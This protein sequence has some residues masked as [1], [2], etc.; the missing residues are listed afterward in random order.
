M[1]NMD[2]VKSLIIGLKTE[3]ALTK[4]E[5][6]AINFA[7]MVLGLY[8]DMEASVEAEAK[9]FEYRFKRRSQHK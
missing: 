9:D 3:Y 7:V 6:D 2:T 1:I 4:N 8:E 5:K